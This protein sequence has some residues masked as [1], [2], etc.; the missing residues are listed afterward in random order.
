LAFATDAAP[1]DPT[2]SC[3]CCIHFSRAYLRHLFKANEL[4]GYTLLSLHNLTLLTTLMREMRAAILDGTFDGYASDF[5]AR[6]CVAGEEASVPS[7]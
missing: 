4:L 5:L 1:L 7:G 2:C 3:Y 6:Y